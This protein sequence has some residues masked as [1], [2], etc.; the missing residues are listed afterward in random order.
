MNLDLYNF[1]LKQIFNATRKTNK[2]H[3]HFQK[4]TS[5]YTTYLSLWKNCHI[6]YFEVTFFF[7]FKL[8]TV[9]HCR[10]FFMYKLFCIC[11]KIGS[12]SLAFFLHSNYRYIQS[13][14]GLF[15]QKSVSFF[16][17]Q[18]IGIYKTK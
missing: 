14:V 1:C 6:M 7:F 11:C 5:L 4:V 10:S 9:F 13:K 3:H 8:K 17:I 2:L 12:K 15:V 18:I 16:C